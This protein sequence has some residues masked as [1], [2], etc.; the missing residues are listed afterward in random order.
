MKTF[1]SLLLFA[2][3][4]M[5]FLLLMKQIDVCNPHERLK[6]KSVHQNTL[7]SVVNC[8]GKE[9]LQRKE[10]IVTSIN[11]IAKQKSKKGGC[12]FH[13]FSEV[14]MHQTGFKTT[15]CELLPVIKSNGPPESVAP[16][17][18]CFGC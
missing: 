5:V 16:A 10:N 3:P 7:S 2:L 1:P 15:L 12:K 9:Q 13:L 14:I 4:V 8:T 18:G 17:L 6:R 11:C